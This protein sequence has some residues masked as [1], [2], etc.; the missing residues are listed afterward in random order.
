MEERPEPIGGSSSSS[1][2]VVWAALAV[3]AVGVLLY[4]LFVPRKPATTT[5]GSSHPAI[6][7]KLAVLQLEPLTGDGQPVTLDAVRGKVVM[8]NYWGTWC[9]PCRVEFPHLVELE[10]RLRSRGE[11]Q[12]VSVSCGRGLEENLP[13]LESNTSAFLQQS[14]ADFPTYADPDGTSRLGLVD[15]A[16]LDGFA[17]PTTVLLDGTGTIRALWIGYDYG[18]EIE[19]ADMVEEVLASAQRKDSR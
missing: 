5:I 8:I 7:K 11:F 10:R 2:L 18:Y 1:S 19:M 12:F 6:G 14:G 17:Y 15:N 4:L 3:I 9:P 16:Q 13:V